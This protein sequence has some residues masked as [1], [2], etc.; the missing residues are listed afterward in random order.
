MKY[1]SDSGVDNSADSDLTRLTSLSNRSFTNLGWGMAFF[2]P[3]SVT[4]VYN[5]M[6]KGGIPGRRGGVSLARGGVSLAG[7]G[8]GFQ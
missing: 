1:Y 2:V 6:E 8:E 4:V 5:W 7:G 3:L